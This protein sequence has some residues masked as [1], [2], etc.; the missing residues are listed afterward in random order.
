[1]AAASSLLIEK[2]AVTSPRST[3]AKTLPLT[4]K[5]GCWKRKWAASCTSGNSVAKR[6]IASSATTAGSP[7]LDQHDRSE[8]TNASGEERSSRRSATKRVREQAQS[9]PEHPDVLADCDARSARPDRPWWMHRWRPGVHRHEA[10]GEDGQGRP[11]DSVG[12]QRVEGQD[13]G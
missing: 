12:D 1:M 6:R 8:S 4:L 7:T 11:G 13:P 9:D 5:V 3:P 2:T 10:T